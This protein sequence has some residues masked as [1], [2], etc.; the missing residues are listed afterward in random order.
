MIKKYMMTGLL[1]AALTLGGCGRNE[2]SISLETHRNQG[3][4]YLTQ[5]DYQS[6]ISELSAALEL[7]ADS[8][9]EVMRDIMLY[10]VSALYQKED[11]TG[12]IGVC[13][14]LITL[15]SGCY[16]A[17]IMAYQCYVQMNQS[18]NGDRYLQ[19]A[20]GIENE[21]GAVY[22]AQIY[23]MTEDY[24]S[25]R[26]EL[27]SLV[28]EK[29]PEAML[30]LASVYLE[31]ND[32]AHARSTY[33]SYM[34]EHGESVQGYNGLVLCDIADEDYTA[35]LAHVETGLALE[36]DESKADLQYNEIVIYEKQHQWIQ[37]KAK[38]AEYAVRYPND[39]RGQRENEFLAT[40]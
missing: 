28:E 13:D 9:K 6:A 24:E 8:D 10:Q 40:R 39:E 3:I 5:G 17:Y 18:A 36:T 37:A 14:K 7:A 16:D 23:C 11:Y 32:S 20:L 19:E 34:D 4:E 31:L 33:Q 26:N 38:A 21:D 22:R 1:I 35:A 2:R 25:A 12:A 30:L 27:T 29:D 15:D